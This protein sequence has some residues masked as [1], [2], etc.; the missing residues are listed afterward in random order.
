MPRL[1]RWLCFVDVSLFLARH[2]ALSLPIYFEE[3][4]DNILRSVILLKK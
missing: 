2:R 4:L 3:K 1:H